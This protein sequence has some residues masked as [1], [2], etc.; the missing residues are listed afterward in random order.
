[1]IK[2]GSHV[3]FRKPDYLVG[4][5]EE[6]L[7]NGANCAMIY[8]GPPQSTLRV[9]PENYL[10]DE[11]F[12]GYAAKIEPKDIVIHAP[13]II[14]MASKSKAEFSRNF[15]IDEISRANQIGCRYLVIHPGSATDLSK[16]EALEQLIENLK[17]VLNRSKNITICIE[18]MAGKG[19][20]ICTNFEDIM[21]VINEINSNRIAICLD[22]CHV[23]DAGCDIKEYD[24]FKK[25]LVERD[26]LKHIKVIHLNDSL[27]PLN[28]HRDR[29]ANIGNGL[30]GL[31]AL[32]KIVWDVNFD[33]V[34]IILE[35][36]YI[37][38]TISPY[39]EEIALL[40]KQ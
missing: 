19:N 5:I 26:I 23:W 16:Q 40:L 11:Y 6:S 9:S 39:K 3:S 21:Y 38:G 28:S 7:N 29:H 25:M 37:N 1:M 12:A 31:D 27:N 4:A 15:L 22:T 24:G 33:D 8:L 14:N 2:L 36:P 18:T 10:L 13:Y 30:I 17:F 34:P 20:E 35:T 32:K